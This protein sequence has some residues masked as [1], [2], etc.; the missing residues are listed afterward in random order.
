[1]ARRTGDHLDLHPFVVFHNE[2]VAVFNGLRGKAPS[3]LEYDTGQKSNI[4]TLAADYQDHLAKPV[5]PRSSTLELWNFGTLA[6]D[7]TPH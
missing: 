7:V 4:E 3:Y 2:R 6:H 1:M 5:D